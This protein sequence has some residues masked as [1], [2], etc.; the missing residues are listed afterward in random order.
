MLIG[1]YIGK[2]SGKGR[3]AL[4]AKLR[5]EMGDDVVVVRWY[6]G[7]LAVLISEKWRRLVEGLGEKRW[8]VAARETDRFLLS[9]AFE[10]ALDEQGRFVVPV[11]LRGYAN[12]REEVVFLGLWDRVEIWDRD[13]YLDYQKGL[14]TRA[15]EMM[16]TLTRRGRKD[17]SAG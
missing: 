13:L 17:E 15:P 14:V 5:D 16:E 9:G 1:E 11:E 8:E 4:P 10:V 6:E 2:I 3:V 7:C 12:L